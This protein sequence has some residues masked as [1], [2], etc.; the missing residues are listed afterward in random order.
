MLSHLFK[1]VFSHWCCYK[2][3]GRVVFENHNAGVSSA[4]TDAWFGVISSKSTTLLQKHP[5]IIFPFA[6]ISLSLFFSTLFPCSPD[7][8]GFYFHASLLVVLPNPLL[9]LPSFLYSPFIKKIYM[10][11]SLRIRWILVKE[12]MDINSEKNSSGK[13]KAS[14]N[15]TD[16]ISP[17]GVFVLS[18]SLYFK[19][20]DWYIYERDYFTSSPLITGN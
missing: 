13:Q 4:L 7:Q 19:D 9:P 17:S 12:Q 15:A 8:G 16:V 6:V 2:Q 3:W 5:H 10:Y 18:T 11:F 20:R 1:Q 14:E